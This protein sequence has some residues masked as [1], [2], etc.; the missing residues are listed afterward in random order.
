MT[1]HTPPTA[2]YDVEAIRA[3][4]PIL[5]ERPYG[6]PLVYL[7][8]AA[9]AQ[10][11]RAV[12]ERMVHAYEHEYA[13]VHRGLHFL[14]NAATEAYE[15][16]RERVRRF[17]NAESSD[18][19]VFTRSASEAINLVAASFGLQHIGAGD[20]I[21]LT[22]MEHHSNIVPWHFHRERK[23]AVLTWVDV[24]DDG[25]FSL[26]AFERS[27]TPR[28]KIVAVTQMSNVL[29]T[30]PPIKEIVRIAHARGVPVLVDGSQGAVHLD[31]DVRDLD[32]DFYAFT[33]HK[34]Y[35]PTGIGVLYG[36]RALL[37]SLPPFNG[38]GEMI[39]TVTRDAVTYNPPPHRFEAGTPPIVQAIGLAAA[40]DYVEAIGRARIRDH[41]ESLRAYA[42]ERLGAINS[43][44]VIGAA[45]GK[46][47]IVSF[48]MDNAHAHDVATVIDRAGVAVR[49]GTHCAMP[50]LQRF[51]VTSTCRASFA[52]YNT[53]AE[54]DALADALTRA[55]KLFA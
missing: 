55:H 41:E 45:P 30:A 44:R 26:E 35:G 28:T 49:A 27:L 14:A 20:E 54:V 21:V 13:N 40:I 31:V 4:F 1:I 50:L 37:E 53:R 34:V 12:I 51:G 16:A 18:E 6:K 25:A 39:D 17:L 32:A 7:D 47:P 19:I 33:G 5:S 24:D 42:Q 9:S 38:G 22:V 11:P 8:N 48:T 46:G 15:A 2:P 3:D 23:G 10:K 36:K 43:L 29:G 52:L